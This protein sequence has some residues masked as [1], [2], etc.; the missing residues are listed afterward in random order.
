MKV[1][2]SIVGFVAIT[3]L[4]VV[5]NAAIAQDATANAQNT[6]ATIGQNLQGSINSTVNCCCSSTST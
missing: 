2:R 1:W 6:A 3:A 5:Q 4:I